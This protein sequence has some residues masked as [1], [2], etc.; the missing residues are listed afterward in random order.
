MEDDSYKSLYTK[1]LL[2]YNSIK[3]DLKH[4]YEVHFMYKNQVISGIVE[5]IS[6]GYD[7]KPIYVVNDV[8]GVKRAIR[9]EDFVYVNRFDS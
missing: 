4:K 3:H 2:L 9:S 1:Y 7:N 6:D 8:N 5:H